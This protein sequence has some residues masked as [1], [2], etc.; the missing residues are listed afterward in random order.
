MADPGAPAL[1]RRELPVPG[2][3][4]TYPAGFGIQLQHPK[5]VGAGHRDGHGG[6][7][8]EGLVDLSHEVD[9]DEHGRI[10]PL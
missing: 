8:H 5:D 7:H 6:G 10:F 3:D 2:S 1:P 9:Q 4:H